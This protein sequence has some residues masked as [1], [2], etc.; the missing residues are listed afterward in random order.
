M[1][2]L[3]IFGLLGIASTKRAPA[4]C[5]SPGSDRHRHISVVMPNNIDFETEHHEELLDQKRY[6][7]GPMA[8]FI[9][10]N[11]HMNL[12]CTCMRHVF[13]LGPPL[14]HLEN[15]RPDLIDDFFDQRM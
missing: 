5:L 9:A 12:R 11:F 4:I 7:F 8:A 14:V 13:V 10:A 2:L 15:K 3:P 6:K 1:L